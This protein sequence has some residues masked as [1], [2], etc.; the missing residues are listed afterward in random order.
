VWLK[1]WIPEY[2]PLGT[3]PRAAAGAEP[4]IARRAR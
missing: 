3:T 4:A 1:A 2:L